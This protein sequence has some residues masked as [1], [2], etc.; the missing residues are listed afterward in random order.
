M[1]RKKKILFTCLLT[2]IIILVGISRIY[3]GV[4]Y[5]SDVIG[6][7]SLGLV[8]LVLFINYVYKKKES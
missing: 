7:F 2:I 8:H 1:A 4:H 6:A 3:L 5:A